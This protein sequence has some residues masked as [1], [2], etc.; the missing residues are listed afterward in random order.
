MKILKR[1]LCINTIKFVLGKKFQIKKYRLYIIKAMNM[2]NL[3]S[4]GPSGLI[5][6]IKKYQKQL[7]I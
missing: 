3:T 6:S 4:N 2:I 5:S 7:C 1:N